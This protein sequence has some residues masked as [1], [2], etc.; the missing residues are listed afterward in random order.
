VQSLLYCVCKYGLLCCIR[1]GIIYKLDNI[2][3]YIVLEF[4]IE[5]FRLLISMSTLYFFFFIVMY[6]AL[7]IRVFR[8]FTVS[9][10]AYACSVCIIYNNDVGRFK[11][12]LPLSE[13]RRRW[14]VNQLPD[15]II[16]TSYIHCTYIIICIY[17]SY[18]FRTI[19]V[20]YTR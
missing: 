15:D 5:D 8:R 6:I 17:S 16:Y 12:K 7:N 13:E 3:L 19:I 18:D 1:V 10:S 14:R 9:V 11:D 20:T 2:I 4:W